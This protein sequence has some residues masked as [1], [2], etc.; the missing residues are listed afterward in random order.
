MT[1]ATFQDVSDWTER[2]SLFW[3]YVAIVQS[4][5]RS[6]KTWIFVPLFFIG[7]VLL[8]QL[9]PARILR[10]IKELNAVLPTIKDDG[11]LEFLRDMLTLVYGTGCFYRRLCLRR[12]AM[13][14][15]L[16]EID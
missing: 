6:A 14:E 1:A 8:A 13:Q 5:Y 9:F 7:A 12:K 16:C 2:D 10:H 4:A 15:A 11:E 3:H